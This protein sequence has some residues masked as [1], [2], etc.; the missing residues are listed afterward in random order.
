MLKLSAFALVIITIVVSCAKID[1][2]HKPTY[3]SSDFLAPGPIPGLLQKGAALAVSV[4]ARTGKLIVL[5]TLTGET[6]ISCGKPNLENSDLEY[7]I[8]A[9]SKKKNRSKKNKVNS[10]CDFKFI[11][12]SEQLLEAL[13][14]T[15]SSI[16][17]TALVNG[18]IVSL[19]VHRPLIFGYEGS[20]C[21][22]VN[23]DGEQ[24]INCVSQEQKCQS[25][26]NHRMFRLPYPL[27]EFFLDFPECEGHITE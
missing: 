13:K 21:N 11:D 19:H 2:Q 20:I 3:T 26:R 27:S 18:K 15:E 1:H 16:K 22:S 17:A 10:N 12:P 5:N 23:Q 9:Q 24:Y 6:A 14:F 7:G 8:S 25:Y 4:D